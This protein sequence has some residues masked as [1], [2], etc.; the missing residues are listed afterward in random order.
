MASALAH[1]RHEVSRADVSRHHAWQV[2]ADL[3]ALQADHA[4]VKS[5]NASLAAAIAA[6]SNENAA[7]SDSIA[8]LTRDN[9]ASADHIAALTR[10]RDDYRAAVERF[11]RSKSWRYL[12]PA[13]AIGRRLRQWLRIQP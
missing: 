8:A 4:T 10:E 6:L 11:A 3:D 12:A 13:R 2:E 1:S 7:R 5:E 9:V